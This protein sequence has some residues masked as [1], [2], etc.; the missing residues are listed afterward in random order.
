MEININ[1]LNKIV[2]IAEGLERKYNIVGY[3][4]FSTLKEFKKDIKDFI[5]YGNI[6][7]L[8]SYYVDFKK[9]NKNSNKKEINA[10]IEMLQKVN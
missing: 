2:A 1:K 6:N 4:K 3:M 9:Y 8:I 7:D 10:F 5:K